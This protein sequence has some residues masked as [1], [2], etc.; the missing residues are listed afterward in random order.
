MKTEKIYKILDNK[1]VNNARLSYL[2]FGPTGLNKGACRVKFYHKLQ[3]KRFTDNELEW[4]EA[5]MDEIFG[6]PQKA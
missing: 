1:L 5:K 2:L 6:N 3:G 4:L